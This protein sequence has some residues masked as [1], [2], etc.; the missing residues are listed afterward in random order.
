MVCT[1]AASAELIVS[2][3]IA[4]TSQVGE[5]SAVQLLVSILWISAFGH[6]VTATLNVIKGTGVLDNNWTVFCWLYPHKFT[7]GVFV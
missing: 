2:D 1:G 6:S 7:S 5:S 3:A 4:S